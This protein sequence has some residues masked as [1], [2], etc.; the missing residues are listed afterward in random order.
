M[1][2]LEVEGIVF[3]KI[4]VDTGSAVDIIPQK[5]LRSL[6]QPI[7]MIKQEMTPLASFE[8][9][10][11]HP[12]GIISLT[13]RTHDLE[14]KTEFTVVSHPIPFDAIIGRPWMH[15]MRAVPSVYHQY[16]KFLSSTSEKTILGSQKRARACYMS[17]FQKMSQ[18][19][20]NIQLAR[21]LSVEYSAKDLSSVVGLEE[22]SPKKVLTS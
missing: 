11:I 15:Q 1:I 8:G 21:E 3:S 12:L 22:S 5:I 17:E 2:T 19:E 20:E 4:L 9:K 7:P 16:V 10:S 18:R 6:K 14:L 13:T